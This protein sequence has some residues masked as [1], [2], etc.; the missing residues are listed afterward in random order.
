[1][2]IFA[3]FYASVGFAIFLFFVSLISQQYSVF[4]AKQLFD[5]IT[6]AG[7]AGLRLG[8]AALVLLAITRP[9]RFGMPKVS[10]PILVCYGASI[11][12]M[13]LLY[14]MALNHIPQG[15]A[16]GVVFTGPLVISICTSRSLCDLIGV[17]LAAIG[18]YFLLPIS[19]S[20]ANINTTGIL[21]ALAS[22]VAWASYILL[23][24]RVAESGQRAP[25]AFG[26]FFATMVTLPIGIHTSE[27]SLFSMDV[28]PFAAVL[29]ILSADRKSVV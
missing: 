18:M 28:L 8:I 26:M 9:W 25:V 22:A 3:K 12:L 20:S 29:S 14:Y 15:I 1:M 16:A 21:F 24:K 6:P 4:F 13:N 27:T 10:L 19:Q 11:G 2:N 17:A 7:T 5:V 23:G